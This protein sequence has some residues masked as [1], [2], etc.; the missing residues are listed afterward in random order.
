M[1][2][3]LFPRRRTSYYNICIDGHR[4]PS[5]LEYTTYLS[6]LTTNILTSRLRRCNYLVRGSYGVLS[7]GVKGSGLTLCNKYSRSIIKSSG[8]AGEDI[9]LTTRLVFGSGAL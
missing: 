9:E 4:I 7:G 6:L 2:L 3:R 8:R 5:S 1:A